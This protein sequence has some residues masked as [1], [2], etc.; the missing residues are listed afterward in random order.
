[1]GA[2]V[3]TWYGR[4]SDGDWSIFVQAFDADGFLNGATVQLEALDNITG[5][6]Y[7]P[8]IT[9]VG[10]DGAYVVTWSGED[11]DGD[12]SIFVQAFNAYG[13]FNGDTVQL[14]A[15]GKTNGDDESPQITAVGTDG[16]Y[17]VTWYGDDSDGDTSIF[18][19]AFNADGSVNGDTVQLEALG[20]TSGY[21]GY[22]QITAVG[23]DGAYVVTWY[24]ADSDGDYSIF[25]QAFNADG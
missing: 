17:V 9:A 19:Q 8:Q 20:K 7:L 6:D 10:T 25:V 13:S 11:S 1:D 16:A 18:V 2:Y 12:W 4:D 21:D 14:E 15:L 24:G 22:P 3:V 5:D 23:S